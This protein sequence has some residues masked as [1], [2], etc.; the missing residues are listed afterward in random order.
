MKKIIQIFSLLSLVF[1]FTAVSASAQSKLGSEVEIPFAFNVA[2]HSYEAGTYILQLQ[3]YSVGSA[4]L[5]IHDTKTNEIQNVL[6][7]ANGEEPGAEI[8]LVFETVDR[9]RRLAKIVTSDRTYALVRS[10]AERNAAK[11]REVE[12]AASVGGAN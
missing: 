12:K 1:L 3:K 5:S 9:E 2:D 6:L 8:K 7:N 11:A 4:T 10:K